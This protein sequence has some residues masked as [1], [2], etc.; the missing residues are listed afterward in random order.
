MPCPCHSY[1]WDQHSFF[2]VHCIHASIYQLLIKF[3]PYHHVMLSLI[4]HYH[5][6][7]FG[8]HFHNYVKVLCYCSLSL[9]FSLITQLFPSPIVSFT[10][11]YWTLNPWVLFSFNHISSQ[12]NPFL[13]ECGLLSLACPSGILLF[14]ISISPH[15]SWWY[16]LVTY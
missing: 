3:K 14:Q 7:V 10:L 12:L 9:R 15:I 16:P 8:F 2:R 1:Y 4:T 6:E 13:I 5:H 11:R